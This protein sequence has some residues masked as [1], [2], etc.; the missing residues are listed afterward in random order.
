MISDKIRKQLER[1]EG[2][3][4]EALGPLAEEYRL[5]VDKVNA[6]LDEALELLSKGLRSEAIQLA[7]ARP[8]V[9]EWA[10][11]LD[12]QEFPDFVE[13]LQFLSIPVPE[14]INR[15]AVEQLQQA[16]IEEQPL[17]SLM[18]EHRRLAIGKAPLVWRLKVLRQISRQDVANP[19][20]LED[21]EQWER[22]RLKELPEEVRNAKKSRDLS[23]TAALAEELTSTAWRIQIPDQMRKEVVSAFETLKLNDQTQ[24]AEKL[25]E[26]LN[27]AFSEMD[28]TKLRSLRAGYQELEK[29]MISGMPNN[30]REMAEPALLWLEQRDGDLKAE[31]SHRLACVS[32]AK[33]IE[34]DRP[35]VD[36]QNA[37]HMVLRWDLG[38]DPL[39]EERYE[40]IVSRKQH[41]SARRSQLTIVALAASAVV[42]ISIVGMLLW[43]RTAN[44]EKI[45]VVTELSSL[46]EQGKLNEAT[47]LI[48]R[49]KSQK[50]H[51]IQVTEIAS[52]IGQL[53]AKTTAE[54]SRVETLK[55][56]VEQ[57][58]L[59]DAS[60]IDKEILRK[61]EEVATTDEEKATLFQIRRR[62]EK[63]ETEVQA[64]QLSNVRDRVAE[65]D[66]QLAAFEKE[67]DFAKGEEHLADLQLR[68]DKLKTE[69]PKSGPRA[70]DLVEISKKRLDSLRSAMREAIRNTAKADQLL[71]VVREADSIQKLGL[72]LDAFLAEAP[73]SPW[74]AEFTRA[75]REKTLWTKLLDWNAISE[76]VDKALK[77]GIDPAE[78]EQILTSSE[79][80][81]A[82]L[83]TH[84]AI[85]KSSN[86]REDVQLIPK[87]TDLLEFL[88]S[89][90]SDA[91]MKDLRTILGQ[92]KPAAGGA[93]TRV[94]VYLHDS[95][96]QKMKVKINE[97]NT[98]SKLGLEVVADETG[99][100]R[101]ESVTGKIEVLEEPR[102]TMR[103]L[104]NSLTSAKRSI[105][106][107]WDKQL[108]QQI[109]IILKNDKLDAM[110]KETL[111]A[112]LVEA[113]IAGSVF[114]QEELKS[115][116][117]LLASR[118]EDR[119]R[120]YEAA[121]FQS[122]LPDDIGQPLKEAFA[123]AFKKVSSNRDL[124]AGVG[125][126][127]Y[128][129]VGL[130]DRDKAGNIQARLS[131]DITNGQLF[132]VVENP[133][134]PN[135]LRLVNAGTVV[136]KEV[137]LQKKSDIEIA[138]RPLFS[139]TNSD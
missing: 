83:G 63:H 101:N 77:D 30:L 136:N 139:L 125:R 38:I 10:S 113:A 52:L 109:G 106:V 99:A 107:E 96:Y 134:V 40:S 37:Y 65:I 61:A 23:L 32:L 95:N 31:E 24:R 88:I 115:T 124:I 103:L 51:L 117:E 133:T 110:I 45:A 118:S 25:V 56:L 90:L 116:S 138:G 89:D 119:Q 3:N 60:L 57:V 43:I 62:V 112:R 74:T 50:P 42:L 102:A 36:L 53:E 127:K 28:E 8:N 22:S 84:P 26:K 16:M 104:T 12:F 44:Q 80:M 131:A 92:G 34:D 49:F 132:V 76:Q 69:F 126:K 108:L 81:L 82:I 59:Q 39:L 68:L 121:E 105:V 137:H 98:G 20:W 73:Q 2:L 114:L 123:A 1:V 27:V 66:L 122:K 55:R 78:A 19:V 91:V 48:G 94:R 71:R 13:I 129:M 130:L 35:L 29:S 86:W 21:I 70:S 33:A 11:Q 54:Q 7:N 79:P 120:W 64:S 58:D 135:G 111:I 17:E 75:A 41:Q 87:R 4:A 47:A 6:R 14:S 67:P 85:E 72:A 100:V 46:V 18:R 9:I 97:S 128:F 5:E 93:F 15:N